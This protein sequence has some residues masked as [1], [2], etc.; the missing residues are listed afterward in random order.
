[1]PSFIDIT[2]QR[3]GRLVAVKPVGRSDGKVVWMLTC[4]CGRSTQTKVNLLRRGSTTSCGCYWRE[5]CAK[6]CRRRTRHGESRHGGE[7]TRTYRTWEA[8]RARCR[9]PNNPNYKHYGAR[10]IAICARWDVYENFLAD[11][12]NRPPGRSLDRIDNN[13]GYAPENCRWA[14]PKQQRANQRHR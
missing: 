6:A 8:M 13:A 4:D 7:T 9:N 12:G 11:M 14:T 5:Q 10:G 2:G 1:M 3:F